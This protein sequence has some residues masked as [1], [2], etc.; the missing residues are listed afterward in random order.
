MSVCCPTL[1]WL[2]C[3]CWLMRWACVW[4]CTLSPQGP[5]GYSM[6]SFA[7]GLCN[8][9]P[10]LVNPSRCRLAASMHL[11]WWGEDS[12]PLSSPFPLRSIIRPIVIARQHFFL[13]CNYSWICPVC[14]LLHSQAERWGGRVAIPKEGNEEVCP[15]LKVNHPIKETCDPGKVQ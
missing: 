15:T 4:P 3:L 14:G 5:G 2:K 1:P 11:F 6:V 12:V 13:T 7:G 9:T 10:R 8:T